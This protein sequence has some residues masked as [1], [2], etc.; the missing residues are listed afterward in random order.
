M[1]TVLR[2]IAVGHVN[3]N[4]RDITVLLTNHFNTQETVCKANNIRLITENSAL[5]LCRLHLY[6]TL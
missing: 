4:V 6:Q 1:Q 2:D 3:T 5:I